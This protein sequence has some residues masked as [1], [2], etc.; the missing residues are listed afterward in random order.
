METLSE[1][2][3]ISSLSVNYDKS[4][5][6]WIGSEKESDKPVLGM[7]NINLTTDTIRI[8]G[9]YFT[10]N[11]KLLIEQNFD[12][13]LNNFRT[14]LN[15]LKG[16]TLSIYGK[17]II[18]KTLAIP[19]VLYVSGLAVIPTNFGK[20]IKD[21]MLK[22]LWHGKN[23]KIKYSALINEHCNGGINFPDIDSILHVQNIMWVKRLLSKDDNQWKTVPLQYIHDLG[24]RNTIGD[25]FNVNSLAKQTPPFY[26][27]CFKSWSK[28]VISDPKTVQE[29]LI[30]P[31]WN[32]KKVPLDLPLSFIKLLLN[33]D[34]YI[35]K[36]LYYPN[37]KLKL[38]TDIFPKES[39]AY[40]KYFI[41][42]SSFI[43]QIPEGWKQSIQRISAQEFINHYN[44]SLCGLISLNGNIVKI[45]K[46]LSKTLY[47]SI[48]EKKIT[49]P[50]KK[51]ILEDCYGANFI[52]KDIC[53]N[54][55][56]TTVDQ[57]TRAFQ[58]K[59][60]H[61]ILPVNYKLYKWKI[62]D[63][64]RC[65]YCFIQ[66]ETIEHLFCHCTVAITFYRQ[67]QEWANNLFN[68][69]LPEPTPCILLYGVVPWT[70]DNA[71]VNHII[72]IYKQILYFKRDMKIDHFMPLFVNKFNESYQIEEY[73]AHSKNK[74]L[75]HNSKWK[76]YKF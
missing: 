66:N 50:S 7:K 8:L 17:T 59:L 70:K 62:L 54:I 60:M 63:S 31:L 5:I 1:F 30:Q 12:R 18:L 48:V 51:T 69:V 28:Y 45:E 23:P 10:Y 35:V 64:P 75:I 15:I 9:I 52:W 43:K 46:L 47:S 36:H 26:K 22:F 16:R 61:D 11:Q 21:A 42:W 14:V 49:W 40:Q 71:F 32:N 73:I 76:Q 56:K 6:A 65:S 3:K 37:G 20:E 4:E 39:Q 74:L 33:S 67:I 41:T 19:K 72:L 44:K 55:Y 25:N 29:I 53:M 58:Y 34:T 38:F 13:V 27:N 24:G 68:I 57:F 2:S